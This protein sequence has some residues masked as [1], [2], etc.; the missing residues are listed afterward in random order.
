MKKTT[1]LLLM[2][3]L[4]HGYDAEIK[5]A[6]VT[7]LVNDKSMT[8]KAGEKFTLQAGDIVC[9]DGG[10]GRVVITGPGYKKQ[11]GRHTKGCKHLPGDVKEQGKFPKQ[12]AHKIVALF[13]KAE[14]EKVVGV[15][16]K[17]ADISV[18]KAPIILNQ[19]DK[20]LVIENNR[21][22]LPVTLIIKNPKDQTVGEMI[23]EEDMT[24]SFV[25]PKKFLKNGYMVIVKDGLDDIVVDSKIVIK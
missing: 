16:R 10:K 9:F 20:Y 4:V 21:W 17:S 22:T 13:S 2:T 3:V 1:L 24:T 12:M 14:E 18:M 8:H 25:L 23:N 6:D 11:I 7:L 15:S 5:K 19:K